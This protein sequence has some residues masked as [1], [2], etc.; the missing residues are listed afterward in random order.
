MMKKNI[1]KTVIIGS[2][3]FIGTA[4]CKEL[5]KINK[6][7]CPLSSNDVNLLKLDSIDK[8]A[9][10]INSN[11][12]VVFI[13]AIAPC[14][15]EDSYEKN[16]TMVKNF[17]LSIEKNRPRHIIY[18][19]SDAV[20]Y[21][22]SS[23]IVEDSKKNP[24]NFHAKMHIDREKLFYNYM[25]KNSLM[26]SILRPTLVYGPGDTHNGYGP[27][28]F[29]RSFNSGEDIYLF[30]NGEEQRD[31]IYIIDLVKIISDVIENQ[32]VGDFILATGKVTTFFDIAKI[33]CSIKNDAGIKINF[34]PRVGEM[35]HNGYRAFDIT[36]LYNI[37]PHLK[38][39]TIEEGI[40]K[41]INFMK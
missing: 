12:T 3:G 11:D 14:K 22:S 38:L 18:I 19:S 41:S 6:Y 1:N 40:K 28:K 21:D 23:K 7:F 16:I 31:H 2:S 9:K 25:K 39:T 29:M 17:I 32:I 24:A 27:N 30:G 13:S 37:F 20:Y 33:V 35:P 5:K 26:L 34:K 4:L 15:N 10:I 36:K 8:L